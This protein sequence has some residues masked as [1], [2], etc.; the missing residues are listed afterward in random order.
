MLWRTSETELVELKKSRHKFHFFSDKPP[1]FLSKTL[2]CIILMIITILRVGSSN[3]QTFLQFVFTLSLFFQMLNLFMLLL[4]SFLLL[5][6]PFRLITLSM[7]I[8]HNLLHHYPT[9][10]TALALT[11]SYRTSAVVFASNS[12]VNPILFNVLSS[13]FRQEII[14]NRSNLKS[15]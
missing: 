10:Y 11:L 6:T 1:F 15:L 3:P 13:R 7:S 14:L 9:G 8:M 2:N 12:I 4:V 5:M